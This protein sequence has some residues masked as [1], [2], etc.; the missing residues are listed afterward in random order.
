MPANKIIPENKNKLLVCSQ[1]FYPELI[2]TGQTLT[3]LCEELSEMGIDIEV[4]CGPMTLVDRKSKTPKEIIYKKIKIKR[5]WGTRFPKINLLGKFLN[6]LT[7]MLSI[8]FY[9]IKDKT[10]RPML[11]L[12]NP[13]LLGFIIALIT[14]NPIIFLVFDVYPETIVECGLLPKNSFIVKLWHKMNSY[15][16]SKARD[17]IVIGRFMQERLEKNMSAK[18]ISKIKNIHVWCDD[19]NIHYIAKSSNPLIKEWKLENKFIVLYSGN[20]GRFHDLETILSSAKELKNN[21]KIAFV[22][23]GEGHKKSWAQKFASENNLANCQF[24]TYVPREKLSEVLSLADVGLVSLVKGQEGLSVPSKTFGL[25]AT[26]RPVIAIMN[27]KA[28]IARIVK[29]ENCGILVSPGEIKPLSEAI[30][31]LSKN[32]ELSKTLGQNGKKALIRK[33]SL[34]KAAEA[35]KDLIT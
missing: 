8:F 16:L 14:K 10:Q 7:F 1:L 13:P 33:Y 20:M 6:H 3:E 31:K 29:E 15:I 9:L 23:V 11:V 18:N 27:K 12:T 19:R 24:H 35:Y 28:E 21:P 4:L 26:A 5:V 30:T 32:S 34:K 22:F 2:S 17:I 25:L